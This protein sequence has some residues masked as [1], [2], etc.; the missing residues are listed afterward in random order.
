MIRIF[1][2]AAVLLAL[3]AGPLVAAQAATTT[4][5]APATE[6][7]AVMQGAQPAPAVSAPVS[8][9]APTR[10]QTPAP[11]FP[12]R[13]E[14]PGPATQQ[15]P[16]PDRLI[17][18]GRAP[19]RPPPPQGGELAGYWTG[20]WTKYN[21]S[22]PV[23][24]TFEKT[25]NGYTGWFDSDSL[26]VA[27]IPFSSVAYNEPNVRFR[28]VG[29]TTTSVFDG[30]VSI[31]TM[32]GTFT[33]GP[34]HGTF[35]LTR[36]PAPEVKLRVREVTFS[37]GDVTLAGTLIQPPATHARTRAILFMHGSG[38]EGRWA[39]RYLAQKFALRGVA[40]LIYDKRGVG[41]STD[42]WRRS[43]YSELV[44]DAVAGVRFLQA[45]PDVHPDNVG[46]YGH[47]QGGTIAPMVAERAANL[48]FVI[49]SAPSGLRPERVEEYSVGNAVGISRLAPAER[50]E[51]QAYVREVI[52]V[53]YRG[54][55]RA[56]LDSMVTRYRGRSWFFELPPPDDHYWFL[57]RDIA[58][59]RPIGHWKQVRAR[60]LLVYGR[61]DRR[62][63]ADESLR[64]IRNAVK[65][66][67]GGEHVYRE[68][69][70]PEADHTYRLVTG[71]QDRAW[72]KRVPDYAQRLINWVLWDHG[73]ENT[74]EW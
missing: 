23:S 53:A 21:D 52:S 16:I 49:A 45:L 48:E 39:N 54:K 67:D 60:V 57:S 5:Q 58:R 26:Q 43:T 50:A 32:A 31:S 17:L 63:P 1:P 4:P 71:G 15:S 36:V 47:S 10:T 64:L 59:Y 44:N 6:P 3:T 40:A 42:D 55:D 12:P 74:P 66:G 2:I 28:L 56:I 22:I 13:A 65:E 37:N 69:V 7:P 61:Y 11:V 25:A 34:A 27:G 35:Q 30:A 51:A 46:I 20:T 68:W 38:P 41:A 18:P 62:V 9:P 8:A 29:D 19:P 73:N 72:P 70:I 33:E 14:T 24:V